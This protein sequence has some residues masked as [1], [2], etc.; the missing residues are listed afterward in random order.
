MRR[1]I[2]P[3]FQ[4]IWVVRQSSLRNSE[5]LRVKGQALRQVSVPSVTKFRSAD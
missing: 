2:L 1:A 3:G 4:L 5:A